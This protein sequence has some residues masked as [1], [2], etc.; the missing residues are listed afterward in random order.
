MIYSVTNY[1][2]LFFYFFFVIRPPGAHSYPAT[3][4]PNYPPPGPP[5]P[6]HRAGIQPIESP[7][8]STQDYSGIFIS[9]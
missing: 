9:K 7:A 4:S 2:L 3:S 5:P 6:M 1:K 8:S